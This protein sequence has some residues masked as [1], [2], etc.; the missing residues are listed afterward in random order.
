MSEFNNFTTAGKGYIIGDNHGVVDNREITINHFDQRYNLKERYEKGNEEYEYSAYC[1]G[2]FGNKAFK[3]CVPITFINVHSNN[4][5]MYD[6]IHINVPEN[7]YSELFFN[8]SIMKFKAK[9][10]PYNRKDG[11]KDYSLIITEIYTDSTSKKTNIAYSNS[12]KFKTI[13]LNEE[14]YNLALETIQT[15][16]NE[17]IAELVIRLLTMLDSSL[18]AIDPAIYSGFITNFILTQYFLNTSLNEQCNQ[19]Y[20]IRQLDIDIL[21]DLAKIVSDVIIKI[22]TN[23]NT[24][25]KYKDIFG[26]ICY[27]CNYIQNINKNVSDYKKEKF[28]EYTNINN[29]V[30][31]FG[32]KIN[33]KDTNKMFDKLKKR[34]KDFGFNYPNDK[35]EMEK[36]LWCSVLSMAHHLGY[37]DLLA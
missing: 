8:D 19:N 25:Y 14:T 7:W 29:K 30:S 36:D 22:N 24:M 28:K 5:F 18:S 35:N 31:E 21:F 37:I 16:H 23:S 17:T 10:K 2:K 13:D 12:L 20:I 34:H 4:R 26:H 11:T 27:I 33:Q 15:Y 9:I 1:T 6:H 32:E 3:G